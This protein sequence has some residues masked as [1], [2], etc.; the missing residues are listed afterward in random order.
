MMIFIEQDNP[1]GR[2]QPY[3][4]LKA[5]IMPI[6]NSFKIRFNFF[7][8]LKLISLKV[9]SGKDCRRKLPILFTRCKE[10]MTETA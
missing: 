10:S 6:E 3:L 7:I 2:D 9:I 4:I 1:F 8:L 5:T